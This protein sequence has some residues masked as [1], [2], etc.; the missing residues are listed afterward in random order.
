MK[1]VNKNHN[2]H[3][4]GLGKEVPKNRKYAAIRASGRIIM[5]QPARNATL[6]DN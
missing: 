3:F 1:H 6:K 5:N 2:L 4:G